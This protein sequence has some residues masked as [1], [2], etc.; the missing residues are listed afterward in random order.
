MCIVIVVL[1][2]TTFAFKDTPYNV[3]TYVHSTVYDNMHRQLIPQCQLINQ[4]H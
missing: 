4:Q 1:L 2:I 3:L